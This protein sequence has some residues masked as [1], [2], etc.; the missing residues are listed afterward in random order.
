MKYSS[1]LYN[2]EH[3]SLPILFLGLTAI[4]GIVDAISVLSLGR[5]FVANMTGNVVF[6]GL[7]AA[8]ATG[9]SLGASL[10]ALLGFLIGGFIGGRFIVMFGKDRGRLFAVT[11]IVEFLLILTALITM[12]SL[13]QPTIGV[14]RYVLSMIL[15]V[16]MG[17]QNASVRNLAVPDMTTTVLTMTLTGI[18]ADIHKSGWRSPQIATR[19]LAVF[20]MLLG[21]LVGAELVINRS[22]ISALFL[23]TIITLF[24]LFGALTAA[25]RPGKWRT[26]R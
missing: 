4:T 24:I 26:A 12:F 8:H 18:A 9:F 3:G 6:I 22:A 7:A 14:G 16:M 19:L 1:I 23:A 11:C 10:I 17:I 21:A 2:E 5:V 20:A 13:K 15:A 25:K